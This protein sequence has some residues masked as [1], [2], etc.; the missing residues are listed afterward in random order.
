MAVNTEQVW[1]V[2]DRD[3]DNLRIEWESVDPEKITLKVDPDTVS[4]SYLIFEKDELEE[5][6]KTLSDILDKKVRAQK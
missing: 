6:I 4:G 2:G 3:G 1:L 5:L